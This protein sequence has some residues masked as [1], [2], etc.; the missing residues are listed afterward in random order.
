[1][2]LYVTSIYRSGERKNTSFPI[3][4]FSTKEKAEEAGREKCYYSG[5]KH[6]YE[7]DEFELDY[8]D[9][10]EERPL[11]DIIFPH[12]NPDWKDPKN[13]DLLE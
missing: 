13:K 11:A 4:V 3:G 5:Y 1:M 10:T 9:I 2:Q 8:H 12:G 6:G 7:V